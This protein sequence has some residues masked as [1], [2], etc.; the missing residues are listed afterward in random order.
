MSDNPIQGALKNYF[1]E[2]NIKQVDVALGIGMTPAKLSEIL[3]SKRRLEVGDFFDI[4]DFI[5][6]DPHIFRKNKNTA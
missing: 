2:H 4:C 1:E 3:N 6:A 5:K